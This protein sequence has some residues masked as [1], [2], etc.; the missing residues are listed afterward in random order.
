MS[1][2]ADRMRAGLPCVANN[3]ECKVKNAESGCE[4]AEAADEITRLRAENERL[5]KALEMFACDCT[6]E[7]RCAVPDNCRNFLARRALKEPTHD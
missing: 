3:C 6:L 2:I 5:R 4:C 1:D 7:G